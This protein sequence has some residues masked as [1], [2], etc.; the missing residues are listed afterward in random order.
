MAR[1]RPMVEPGSNARP[2]ATATRASSIRPRCA[3][4]GKKEMRDR[5]IAIDFDRPSQPDNG[6]LVLAHIEVTEAHV[7]RL[8][9]LPAV[10]A[11]ISAAGALRN[12]PLQAQLASLGEDERSLGHQGVAEQNA[13]DAG[14]ERPKCG[15][16][17]LDRPLTEILTVR[18]MPPRTI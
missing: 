14:D 4:R 16:P 6:F 8:Q 15:S 7:L 13:V 11:R 2:A 9:P 3:G 18:P 10:S 5:V 12:D 1:R 17:F